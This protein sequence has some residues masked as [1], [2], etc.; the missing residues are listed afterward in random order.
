MLHKTF[1]ADILELTQSVFINC[2]DFND[3]QTHF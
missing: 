1:Y 3:I 2:A